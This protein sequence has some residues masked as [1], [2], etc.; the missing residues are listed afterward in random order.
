VHKGNHAMN[1][2]R[3]SFEA[4]RKNSANEFV[5]AAYGKKSGKN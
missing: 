2:A 4:S 5:G 1:R 3:L